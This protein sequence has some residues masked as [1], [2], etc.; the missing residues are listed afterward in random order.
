MDLDIYMEIYNNGNDEAGF[1]YD[2][3]GFEDSWEDSDEPIT[4]A[5]EEELRLYHKAA[6]QYRTSY[7]RDY[8]TRRDK[9]EIDQRR[10]AAQIEG[11]SDAFMDYSYRKQER[12]CYEGEVQ[13]YQV[14][15]AVDFFYCIDE[16]LAHFAGDGYKSASIVQQGYFPCNPLIHKSVI[17][18]RAFELYQHLFVCCPQLSIQPYVRAICD[19]QSVRFMNYLCV[20]FS[21]AYDAFIAVKKRVRQRVSIS[22]RR[23]DPDWRSLNACSPCQYPV[24]GK[25]PLEIEFMGAMDRNDSLKRVEQRESPTDGVGEGRLKERFDP[26]V[27]GED[28]FVSEEEAN[29]WERTN[30]PNLDGYQAER[31]EKIGDSMAGVKKC[32]EQWDNMKSGHTDKEKAIF[33]EMGI[34]A[35]TCRHMFVLWLTDM[36]KG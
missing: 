23:N 1:S 9:I 21:S 16:E 6:Y 5:D 10:W 32:E 26:R 25:T 4:T 31:V 34:F 17:S 15:K 20:Q 29:H 27:G 30:W 18:I 36:I 19:F 7:Y 14:S 13:S 33:R 8:R 3:G 28:Y 35:S 24:A 22:L 12:K 2:T 11:M